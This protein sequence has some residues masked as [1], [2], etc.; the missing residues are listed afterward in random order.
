MTMPINIDEIKQFLFDENSLPVNVFKRN[1]WFLRTQSGNFF[2]EF[3]FNK[4]VAMG[5]ND[6]DP[7]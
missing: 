3:F 7:R 4:Y 1:Y 6:V 2:E 5:W